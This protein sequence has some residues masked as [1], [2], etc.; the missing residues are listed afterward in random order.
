MPLATSRLSGEASSVRLVWMVN[1]AGYTHMVQP[2]VVNGLEV[3]PWTVAGFP[4]VAAEH[5]EFC[6]AVT[7]SHQYHPILIHKHIRRIER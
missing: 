6:C 5:A 1:F 3:E 7:I 4:A 2:I